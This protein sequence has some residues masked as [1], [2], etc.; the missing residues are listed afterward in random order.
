MIVWINGT[1][2]AGKTTAGTL[3]AGR[4][5][6]LRVFDPEVVGYLL[7]HSLADHPVSDFQ[8]YESWR[9]LVPVVAD[10]IADATGQSLVAIQTVLDEG[11]WDELVGGLARLGH[12]VVHVLLEAEESVM[13]QRIEAV[14]VERGTRQWRLD[15]LAQYAVARPW[16]VSRADLIIDSTDLTPDEV[17]ARVWV[18][19][20]HLW[21]SATPS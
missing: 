3:L 19:L 6:R 1:F 5:E 8:H 7:R 2:G 20:A 4:D 10:E 12:D 18:H 16:L 21:A 13:V 17:A 15:H 11:Y 14:E 9:R